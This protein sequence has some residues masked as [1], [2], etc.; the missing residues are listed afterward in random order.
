MA[1]S[2]QRITYAPRP[3]A[4]PEAELAALV[5]TYKFVLF[6]SQASK[7]GPHDLTHEVATDW[8]TQKVQDKARK[9]RT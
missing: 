7:G 2:S 1:M 4:T 5:A 6:G 8:R 9:D 3:D